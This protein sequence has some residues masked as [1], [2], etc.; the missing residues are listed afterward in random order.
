MTSKSFLDEAIEVHTAALKVAGLAKRL[1]FYAAW[2]PVIN[3]ERFKPSPEVAKLLK[4]FDDEI[5]NLV[6]TLGLL[7][8]P[9]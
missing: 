5:W 6:K 8:D 2:V 4:E 9:E 1:D 7:N 3:C